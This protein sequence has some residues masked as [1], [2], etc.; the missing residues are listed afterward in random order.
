MNTIPKAILTILVCC[1]LT[2]AQTIKPINIGDKAP[3]T[4]YIIDKKFEQDRRQERELLDL[5]RQQT[6][7]LKELGK[8][9]MDR[10]EFYR[11]EAKR[12]KREV[13]K[14]QFKTVLYF[15][16]GIAL[17]MAAVKVGSKL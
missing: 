11:E 3:F 16:G 7:V 10:T 5:E 12:A 2:L 8:V 1:N 17:G 13:L 15:I 6:A 4:G 9:Q 14:G